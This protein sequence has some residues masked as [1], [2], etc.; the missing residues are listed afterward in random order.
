M[1]KYYLRGKGLEF[2]VLLLVYNAR[3]HAKDFSYDCVQ[4]E[5]LLPNTTLLIQPMDQGVIQGSL[6]TQHLATSCC[7]YGLG[8]RFL[9]KGLL[10]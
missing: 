1:V 10:A 4:I 8:S 9:N 6:Y 3:G 5:F 2:I 7:D